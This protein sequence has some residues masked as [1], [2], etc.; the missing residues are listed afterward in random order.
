MLPLRLSYLAK[1]YA[2]IGH[3]EEASRFVTEAL[4]AIETT[5]ERWFEAEVNR[6]AGE[7]ALKTGRAR[8]G[9]S[10]SLFRPSAC[11]CTALSRQS[12]WSFVLQ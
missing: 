9:E 11:S 12:P 4:S 3:F 2:D 5:K 1:A 8:R 10:G 7:I 6:I